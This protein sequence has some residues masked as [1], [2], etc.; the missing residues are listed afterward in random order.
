MGERVSGEERRK[1]VLKWRPCLGDYGAGLGLATSGEPSWRCGSVK[2][3]KGTVGEWSP[4]EVRCIIAY[5]QC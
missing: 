3:A 2:L 4:I 5:E 1:A